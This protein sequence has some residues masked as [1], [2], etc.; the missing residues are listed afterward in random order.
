MTTA[1][2]R[3]EIDQVE[4]KAVEIKA[5][6]IKAVE[7]KAQESKRAD[8]PTSEQT[9]RL[10]RVICIESFASGDSNKGQSVPWRIKMLLIDLRPD[11]LTNVQTAQQIE[12]QLRVLALHII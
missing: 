6:E 8:Y 11:L 10:H 4:I 5:V 2:A 9:N 12:I 1:P 7:I 3:A